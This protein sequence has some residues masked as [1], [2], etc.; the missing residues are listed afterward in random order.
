MTTPPSPTLL[1]RQVNGVT[2]AYFERNRPHPD[3]PS[4]LFVHATGFHGRIWDRVAQAF[5]QLHTIALE[6]RGHGRSEKRTIPHW[7]ILGKDVEEFVNTLAL[8]N[9]I[10]IG[11]SVGGHALVDAAAN[12][13]HFARLILLDPTIVAPEAYAQSLP[14]AKTGGKIHPAAKRRRYFRSPTHMFEQL[15]NKGSYPLFDAGTFWDYC[16]F[17]LLP[18]AGTA[19]GA[20]EA[21]S[22]PDRNA[23]DTNILPYELACPPLIEASVYMSSR[24]NEGIFDSVRSVSVPVVVLRA[25]LP[26]TIRQPMDFASSPTWPGLA[27]AFPNA[28]E[29]HLSACTHFIPMQFPD[30]VIDTVQSEVDR[31]AS[32]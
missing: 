3:R 16:R 25:K 21:S 15:R 11:H 1:T 31:W 12:N 22:G 27:G 6:L 32:P 23:T 14:S 26:P 17:G 13:H 10:G 9:V 4:L 30:T 7:N 8:H 19:H 24:T 20:R 2:L 5:P 18:T 29:I 28:R